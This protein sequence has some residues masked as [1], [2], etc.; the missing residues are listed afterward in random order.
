MELWG[1]MVLSLR[2]I[3]PESI[4]GLIHF[5]VCRFWVVTFLIFILSC[6]GH[7][8]GSTTLDIVWENER[9][10]GV[11]V[12]AVYLKEVPTDS[13]N[14]SLR[15]YLSTSESRTAILGDYQ[16]ADDGVVFRPLIP[17]TSGLTYEVSVAGTTIG[18]IKIPVPQRTDLP[19]LTAIYPS[20][21][22]LPENTLKFYL[23]FSH[24]MREGQALKHITLLKNGTDT[25][26]GTF[27]D[28]QPELW[29]KDYTLLTLWLD[30]GRIKRDL[31]PNKMLG[32][33]LERATSYTLVVGSDW[34]DIRGAVIAEGFRKDFFVAARDSIRP[35]V[36][37]WT[38]KKPK[39]NT[40]DPLVIQFNEPL[41]CILLNEAVRIIT[42]DGNSVDG[43][44]EL[45]NEE[46]VLEFKPESPWAKGRY[47]VE[48]EERLEDLAGNNLNR[49]FDRDITKETDNSTRKIFTRKFEIQ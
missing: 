15:I 11:I 13:I 44:I 19:A 24:P 45:K 41:D 10:T 21:D 48:S 14:T 32:V 34:A 36:K 28:L 8:E 42:E 26:S 29:N 31:Q 7:K 18:K 6:S 4:K 20:Q 35:D 46:T 37:Q 39:Q 2:W 49:L 16:N 40:I 1:Q 27:L 23:R 5:F 38:L 9:A 43:K 12:P 47:V 33:P 22:T 30:P 3:R 17:F 25:V